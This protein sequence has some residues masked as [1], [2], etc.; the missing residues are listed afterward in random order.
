VWLV[1][2]WQ[3]KDLFREHYGVLLSKR[4]LQRKSA[5]SDGELFT[6]AHMKAMCGHQ[7]TDKLEQMCKDLALSE[8]AS[9]A[10]EAV[11]AASAALPVP[12][13]TVRVL[14]MA[15]WPAMVMLSDTRLPPVMAACVAHFVGY[16]RAQGATRRLN[17]AYGQGSAELVVQFSDK[18]A[19]TVTCGTL[20]A[21]V[22]LVL[23][24]VPR[25]SVRYITSAKRPGE[26]WCVKLRGSGPGCP[27]CCVVRGRDVAAETGIEG[28]V[29]KNI[30]GSML[31]AKDLQV[32][33]KTPASKIIDD[34]HE[35]E[36]NG[37]YRSNAKVCG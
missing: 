28:A 29:L 15:A 14:K 13:F 20:Q 5:S 9:K 12:C 6:I 32:L 3:F 8:D 11:V 24:R 10:Y 22:L 34:G 37:G 25:M 7:Y 36:I 31:F 2:V 35:V 26:G 27:V 21:V 17:W 16:F 18:P 19:V 30:L 33:K 1:F 23:D 4:L